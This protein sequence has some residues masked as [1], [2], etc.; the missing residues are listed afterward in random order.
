MSRVLREVA[1][2]DG[3]LDAVSGKQLLRAESAALN[4]SAALSRTRVVRLVAKEVGVPQKL[5]RGRLYINKSTPKR[6]RARLLA[7]VKGV[8]LIHLNPRDTGK[9]GWRR[10]KGKGVRARGGHHYPDAF[11]ARGLNGRQ[12]VFER[13][14]KVSYR[15]GKKYHHVD[16]VRLPIEKEVERHAARVTREI[17]SSRLGDLLSHEMAWRLQKAGAK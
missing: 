6:R 15:D 17:M 13:N 12:Q 8:S 10:R 2:L 7:Y 1:A 11:V 9:G 3:Q 5:I 4:K 14:L 16:V